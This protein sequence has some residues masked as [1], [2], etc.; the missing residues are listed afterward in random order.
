[1]HE[2]SFPSLFVPCRRIQ[3]VAN[4]EGQ[5]AEGTVMQHVR[6]DG[7]GHRVA[8]AKESNPVPRNAVCQPGFASLIQDACD[9]RDNGQYN[10]PEV[11]R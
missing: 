3:V 4:R 11:S 6:S 9:R 1:V 2:L 8:G 10:P 5:D 7:A